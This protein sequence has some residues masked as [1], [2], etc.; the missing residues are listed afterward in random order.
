M[1]SSIALG[2]DAM[3]LLD[4]GDEQV[5]AASRYTQTISD[6]PASVSLITQP[7][8]QRYGYR[9]VFDVLMAQPGF[10]DASSQWPGIGIRGIALPG[11]FNSRGLVMVNG[12]PLYEPTYGNFFLEH[13]DLAS[14]DRIEMVRGPGSALY[15]SGAVM[16]LINLV[17]RNGRQ[18]PGAAAS[19]EAASHGS[20]KAYVSYGA[21]SDTG[22]DLFLSASATTSRGADVYLREYD[23]PA[24]ANGQYHGLSS[25]NGGGESH[26]LFG[27]L[28]SGDAWLQWMFV[29]GRKHD[30]LASYGT[31]FN[32]DRLLLRESQAVLEAG[33][34][35]SLP[36]GA[37]A[38]ARAYLIDTQ[39]RGDYP[40]NNT[41]PQ[42]PA[43]PTYINVSDLTSTQYGAEFRYDRNFGPHR[44]LLG[45]EAKQVDARHQIGDQPGL[46]RSGV[47]TVDSKPAYGQYS[48]FAQGQYRLDRD[49]QVFLGARYD[50]YRSF[51]LGVNNH[52]SPRLAYVRHFSGGG[53]GKLLYGEAYR[54]PTIYESLYQDGNPRAESLWESPELR[55]EITRTLEA[56]WES[57]PGR[58]FSWGASA[59]LTQLRNYPLLVNTPTFNGHACL[60]AQC[61]QYQ[62]SNETA[63]VAGLEGNLKWRQENG[64]TGYASATLQ[65]GIHASSDKGELPTTP[66]LLLKGGI[67][68]PLSS[69]YWKGA[70][71]A[72]FI[73]RV[74]GRREADGSRPAA[75][76]PA[77]L[78]VHAHLY[79]DKL[80]DGWRT[81]LRAQNLLDRRYYT[82]ASPELPP[83]YRIPGPGRTLSLQLEKKF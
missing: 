55:P 30:P 68:G 13:L 70:L 31:V 32:T 78:L 39:E 63:R 49:S 28:L 79:S 12:M 47:L 37:I 9:T 76:A 6:T 26:R 33:A 27:R 64:L 71:E 35:F 3:G 14:I 38:T 56:V 23:T 54:A 61:N 43:A 74:E 20:Y 58:R 42:T 65:R 53:T 15:G 51:S 5:F 41:I 8:I 83:L 19:F 67:H 77:Y 40:Y 11:D 29:E 25:G 22:Q 81:S 2:H 21:T 1:S 18:H 66:R 45:A 73:G 24:Y 80:A 36:S 34:T 75:A 7:D 69:G 59:Y 44:L 50:L 4:G 48:L 46:A 57:A 82:V 72:S 17:T 62:N 10:Y 60:L 52:L 16:G